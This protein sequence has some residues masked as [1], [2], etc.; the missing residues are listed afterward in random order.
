[1]ASKN[2]VQ[3]GRACWSKKRKDNFFNVL[4]L[5]L[6][7]KIYCIF[8]FKDSYT[9]AMHFQYNFFLSAYLASSVSYQCYWLLHKLCKITN[10]A[11]KKIKKIR[12]LLMRT[13][14]NVIFFLSFFPKIKFILELLPTHWT[15]Q[16]YS[17]WLA[18]W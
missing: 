14:K 7:L 13:K 6:N 3:G 9:I 16:T 10:L 8:F 12:Y 18:R 4:N 15:S 11:K 5:K 1:M 2:L 17:M